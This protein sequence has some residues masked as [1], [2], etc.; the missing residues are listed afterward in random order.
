MNDDC[1]DKE[2]ELNSQSIIWRRMKWMVKGWMTDRC[3]I[4]VMQMTFDKLGQGTR[5][6]VAQDKGL[7]AGM[8]TRGGDRTRERRDGG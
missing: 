5:V 1:M 6:R 7:R 3:S 4:V 8:K 2:N